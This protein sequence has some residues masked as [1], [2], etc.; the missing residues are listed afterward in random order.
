MKNRAEFIVRRVT[1]HMFLNQPAAVLLIGF[2]NMSKTHLRNLLRIKYFRLAGIVDENP[3]ALADGDA[4]AAGV[5]LFQS[6]DEALANSQAKAAL[7][8]TPHH[9]H[10]E[11]CK[12]SL[13][14]GLHVFCEKPVCLQMHEFAELEELAARQR[15]MLAVG[16]MMRFWPNVV[17]A[18]SAIASGQIGEIRHII[19][20]RITQQQDSGNRS[21]T[22]DPKQAGGW[23]LY[24]TGVHEMDAVLY[25]SGATVQQVQAFG[26]RNNPLWND[27][28]E[29][30]IIGRL[31]NGAIFSLN[32]T[33]N[34]GEFAITTRIIGTKGTLLLRQESEVW[35]KGVKLRLPKDTS[36][37]SQLLEFGRAIAKGE[38]HRAEISLVRPTMQA[39]A[40]IRAQLEGANC[41]AAKLSLPN[42]APKAKNHIHASIQ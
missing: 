3:S 37:Y 26:C 10:F 15:R 5:P 32:Q 38:S 29:L 24:G 16:Q 22:Y 41:E 14:Y 6:L 8:A 1:K 40:M 25:V 39:L 11:Q 33:L 2:G 21:W 23:L 31:S 4:M 18:R 35:H 36:F 34:G 7:I 13:E 42:V 20:D 19:R 28:D 27:E 17:W 30:S 12:Q 9:L